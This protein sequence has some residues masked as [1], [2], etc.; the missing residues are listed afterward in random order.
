MIQSNSKQ[1]QSILNQNYYENAMANNCKHCFKMHYQPHCCPTTKSLWLCNSVYCGPPHQSCRIWFSAEATNQKHQCYHDHNFSQIISNIAREFIVLKSQ[2]SLIM[3]VLPHPT[4]VCIMGHSMGWA[5]LAFL[6]SIFN[7]SHE[8]W[9][10]CRF[11]YFTQHKSLVL[12]QP[13]WIKLKP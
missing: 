12:S 11:R 10:K 3:E 9:H 13:Q 6:I 1:S 7:H 2:T 8:I 5:V 4:W